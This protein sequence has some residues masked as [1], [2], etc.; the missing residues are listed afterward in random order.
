[1]MPQTVPMHM[2]L[3]GSARPRWWR[4]AVLLGLALSLSY[5]TRVP[6]ATTW[7]VS[8]SGCTYTS[9]KAAIAAPTTP[10]GDTLAMRPG[11]IPRLTSP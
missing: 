6:A 11:S 1:M 7:T 2:V 4:V 9:I 10:H 3:K 8:A 5:V